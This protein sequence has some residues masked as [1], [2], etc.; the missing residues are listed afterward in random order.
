MV[1][2]SRANSG[3]ALQVADGVPGMADDQKREAMV[4][5][6][7][8]RVHARPMILKMSAPLTSKIT[9]STDNPS[10]AHSFASS[11]TKV[12]TDP[13]NLPQ[14]GA[15]TTTTHAN[16]TTPDDEAVRKAR[17]YSALRWGT[18]PSERDNKDRNEEPGPDHPVHKI[19]LEK[20]EKMRQKKINPVLW[21]EMNENRSGEKGFWA[22]VAGT[23]LGGGVIR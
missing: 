20:Q 15:T 9:M 18:S 8:D 16:N 2:I 7:D 12:E 14:K 17:A 19:P 1:K 21:A 4:V 6:A 3:P 11:A 22:K 10:D 23:A 13:P 5:I